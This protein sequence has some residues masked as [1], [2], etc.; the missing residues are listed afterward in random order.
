MPLAISPA[1][2]VSSRISPSRGSAMP[3][4]LIHIYP[5]KLQFGQE[6]ELTMLPFTNDADGNEIVTFAFQPV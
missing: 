4:S 6:V 5:A 1:A 2:A 3:L